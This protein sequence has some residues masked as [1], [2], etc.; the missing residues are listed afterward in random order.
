FSALDVNTSSPARVASA[1]TVGS[2]PRNKAFPS[3]SNYG[4]GLD[5]WSFYPAACPSDLGGCNTPTNSVAYVAG[6][7]AVAISQY[8][9]KTPAALTADLVNHAVP[10]V[11]GVPSGTTNRRAVPWQI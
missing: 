10:D 4:P 5:V 11:T 1:I 9:N 3:N 2:L 6:Y 8:G 7:L